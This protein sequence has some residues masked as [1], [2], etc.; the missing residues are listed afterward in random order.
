MNPPIPCKSAD[1]C[2]PPLSIA[3][4][5]DPMSLDDFAPEVTEVGVGCPVLRWTTDERGAR[6]AV[7]FSALGFA[8]R[9]QKTHYLMQLDAAADRRLLQLYDLVA[10][11]RWRQPYR[12]LGL[13]ERS[14]VADE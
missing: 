12:Q 13:L 11:L 4:A 2:D 7:A 9:E 14:E 8:I 1:G 10:T 3:T 5:G 6:M